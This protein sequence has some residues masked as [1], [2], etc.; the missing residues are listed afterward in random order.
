MKS[1]V[2][3]LSLMLLAGQAAATQFVDNSRDVIGPRHADK[4]VAAVVRHLSVPESAR[5]KG[6]FL[7]TN[8][9]QRGVVCGFVTARDKTG[10]VPAFQPFLY[11]PGSN[12]AVFM[13]MADFRK[14][15]VGVMNV[16]L[17]SGAGCGA[18]IKL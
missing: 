3:S 12:D 9:S 11:N 14:K 8:A 4:A 16:G 15:G 6:L 10:K 1:L 2:L 17:F 5:F 18:L 7:G 13:P